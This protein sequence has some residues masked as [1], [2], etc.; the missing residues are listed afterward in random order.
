MVVKTMFEDATEPVGSMGD[1]TPHA[2]LS[3]KPRPLFNYFKQRFAEVTNPPIDHLREDQAMSLRLL[4]GT[5]GNLLAETEEL[6]HQI[7]LNSP[8]LRNEELKAH[9]KVGRSARSRAWYW[10]RRFQCRVMTYHVLSAD[11]SHHSYS[12]RH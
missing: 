3:P 12:T 5:R 8:M 10:M 4:L 2:V 9:A 7:R 1:D 6:A 11:A